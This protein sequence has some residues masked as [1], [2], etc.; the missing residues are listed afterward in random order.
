M[1]CRRVVT[2]RSMPVRAAYHTHL[3]ALPAP[4]RRHPGKLSHLATLNMVRSRGAMLKVIG[5]RGVDLNPRN[6]FTFTRFRDE[7]L[8]PD[9]ATLPL[10]ALPRGLEPRASRFVAGRSIPTE[11][12][13]H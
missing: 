1:G 4:C 6:A 11:L 8:K 10:L 9:S 3:T 13:K 7:R 12:R 5:G 2:P